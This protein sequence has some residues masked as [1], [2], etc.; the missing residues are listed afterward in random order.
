M[1]FDYVRLMLMAMGP[2]APYVF[3]ALALVFGAGVVVGAMIW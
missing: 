1:M 3:A 2:V